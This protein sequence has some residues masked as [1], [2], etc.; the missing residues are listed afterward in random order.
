MKFIKLA[1]LINFVCNDYLC[2]LCNILYDCGHHINKVVIK[3]A[4]NLCFEQNRKENIRM[5]HLETD[6][7][8]AVRNRCIIH[9]RV[10]HTIFV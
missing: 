7:S 10:D 8:T 6:I 4:H 1:R 9:R 2:N 3:Y 5:H